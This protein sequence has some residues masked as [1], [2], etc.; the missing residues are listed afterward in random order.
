[1]NSASFFS[2]ASS[3][4]AR[5]GHPVTK[6]SIAT[7]SLN[8]H[9]PHRLTPSFPNHWG[10]PSLAPLLPP[11]FSAPLD[12]YPS[13]PIPTASLSPTSNNF[14]NH[15]TFEI[16]V[17]EP[18]DIQPV[19]LSLQHPTVVLMPSMDASSLLHCNGHMS[20]GTDAFHMD[21]PILVS[22]PADHFDI[23]Y[24]IYVSTASLKGSSTSHDVQIRLIGDIASTSYIPLRSARS[25]D[26]PSSS[27]STSLSR[28]PASMAAPECSNAA[29]STDSGFPVG[30]V[31]EFLIHTPDVGNLLQ[32]ALR[33]ASSNQLDAAWKPD[34]ILVRNDHLHRS[35]SFLCPRWLNHDVGNDIDLYPTGDIAAGRRASRQATR[36]ISADKITCAP[37]P[38]PQARKRFESMRE[39]F[40][41]DS[42][43]SAS[44]GLLKGNDDGTRRV[45]FQLQK[46]AE[47]A[48]HVYLVGSVPALGKW[49]PR[50]AVRMAKYCGL[51]GHWRGEWR[52][53]L[54]LDDDFDEIQ[55]RYMVV[56]E[57][58]SPGCRVAYLTNPQ[59]VLRLSD[60]AN[61]E[62]HAEG[63]AI[64]VKD[65]FRA[66]RTSQ[67]PRRMRSL[68]FI[69]T[70]TILTPHSDAV[71][72]A[73]GFDSSTPGQ[74][75][76]F[77]P[78]NVKRILRGSPVD[79][80]TSQT[81]VSNRHD[82]RDSS[83]NAT[84]ESSGLV[85]DSDSDTDVDEFG[86]D[87]LP[88]T[89]NGMRS[90]EDG[91][92]DG[93]QRSVLRPS[94]QMPTH[95]ISLPG[96]GATNSLSPSDGLSPT[97][98]GSA[99]RVHEDDMVVFAL[100]EKVKSLENENRNLLGER[101]SVIEKYDA[102]NV[103]LQSALKERDG[104]REESSSVRLDA[105]ALRV[106]T[107]GLVSQLQQSHDG[108]AEIIKERDSVREAFESI[109]R[110]Y[111]SVS[112][113]VGALR[114][115]LWETRECSELVE[116]E[117]KAL[118][119]RSAR[120]S[121]GSLAS[122][123]EELRDACDK[124]AKLEADVQAKDDLIAKNNDAVQSLNASVESVRAELSTMAD[125][126]SRTHERCDEL[127]RHLSEKVD[128]YESEISRLNCE[129]EEATNQW[130][131]EFKE[132]RKLFN[133]VQE[134]RGNIRVFCRV[135]PS[136]DGS[137]ANSSNFVSFPDAHLGEH[138]RIQACDKSFEFDHVFQPTSSQ[139]QVY[140][141]TAGV[142]VSVVD[143]YN[144]C[145][146][147]YGQTGS[148]KTYTMN[149]T[150]LD[151]GVN[152][153]ALQNLFE[154]ADQRKEHGC[155]VSVSVAMLEIYNETLRD[156][157]SP[158]DEKGPKLEIRRDP[159]G[160]SA[161]AVHVPNLTEVEVNS[162]DETWDV[163]MKGTLNRSIG[164][165]DMNEHS[166]RSHL[167]LRVTVRCED[168]NSGL[169]T[170]GILH[171]VDLAGSERVS[172][173]N[174]SGSR[175]KEAQHINKSLSSLGD[176]FSA[177]L[178]HAN[179]VPYRNSR[180][181]YLLQD[182]LGGDSK[183]LMFVNVSCDED[184]GP[185][186]LSSLLFAQRVAKVELGSA[187][188]HT[189]RTGEAKAKAALSEKETQNRELMG[190]VVGLQKELKKRDECIAEMRQRSRSLESEVLTFRDKL[191]NA[192]KHEE[193]THDEMDRE[194][195]EAKSAQ[196]V[197]Q[198]E[199]KASV[200]LLK[201]MESSKDEEIRGLVVQLRGVEKE[202][203]ELL[204]E[205]RLRS[206]ADG[207]IVQLKMEHEETKGA[208]KA[209]DE[210]IRRLQTVIRTRE[211][212]I[213]E[214]V[215]QEGKSSEEN[216]REAS[217]E[218]EGRLERQESE[219]FVKN[220]GV[221]RGVPSLAMR[222]A[223]SSATGRSR[224]VRFDE[225][226]AQANLI[227]RKGNHEVVYKRASSLTIPAVG[228]NSAIV[229]PPRRAKDRMLPRAQSSSGMIPK[230]T[231]PK[232]TALRAS[233]AP[234]SG[235][236]PTYAFGSR[237]GGTADKSGG[238]AVRAVPGRVPRSQ[239]GS[240]LPK[241]A[242]MPVVSGNAGGSG[243][244][245]LGSSTGLPRRAR[246]SVPRT[247]TIATLNSNSELSGNRLTG[248][249]GND[250]K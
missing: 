144:V 228:N 45:Q 62:R 114:Q 119:E 133:T 87:D 217:P 5:N 225:S 134:L 16:G 71:M 27:L 205:K 40:S 159:N 206:E 77:R 91:S 214:L 203:V 100:R 194:L 235:R 231:G 11:N 26:P 12:L 20:S 88:P 15:F 76:F 141:E 6:L 113:E 154:T 221:D 158:G 189:E 201:D 67:S 170:C 21:T 89:S 86:Q 41:G 1:M 179:H 193:L 245:Q 110:E 165:T 176:V 85:D 238:G 212:E 28:S 57:G 139:Q 191:D 29:I 30:S 155:D 175:L 103:S 64:Y 98:S 8:G 63:E 136:K 36:R 174:A 192:L 160:S 227:D 243:R 236:R 24:V 198:E 161:N 152:Y 99:E 138:G 43:N 116:Q 223:T 171:L 7:F 146:F 3:I 48:F 23:P 199:L 128:H 32:I 84:E 49:E 54:V 186:T 147:A 247:S 13:A 127:R 108:Q 35:W 96:L 61:R 102:V 104:A 14:G 112:H 56:D 204:K 9:P 211:C 19:F 216:E 172:R 44:D 95:N 60:T 168:L 224:Q 123:R 200:Q 226:E 120:E 122:A 249:H 42:S 2:G 135:R 59:R 93:S 65:S 167:L 69:N 166:S 31:R 131:Q 163:M 242:S 38:V 188:K 55:Y 79:P 111:D 180:L 157:I 22:S 234:S 92:P 18:E 169:K 83:R 210:E 244:G 80:T 219:P 47:T 130:A 126:L 10:T 183:T 239:T 132:R 177:L 218:G 222:R 184:D 118:K 17:P 107:E 37:S 50:H 233:T 232:T 196:D 105:D 52:L 164:R 237:V 101:D 81:A 109:Q 117:N 246:G 149:G 33:H 207:E 74:N 151:R 202:V 137:R 124:I 190:K 185:E 197:L 121:E 90:Q 53:N 208:L 94:E 241:R 97:S 125:E 78:R 73:D 70:Q 46:Y 173:S 66:D 39:R 153:R 215:K 240:S 72:S 230:A 181:T 140:D 106:E 178:S 148:G 143:G 34:R 82:R 250:G 195:H 58:A 142:V 145:V 51:D 68:P 150:E 248:E 220:R 213:A 156:L 182:S 75:S 25:S 4:C 115:Q 162:F 229:G 129:L 209:K 187:K